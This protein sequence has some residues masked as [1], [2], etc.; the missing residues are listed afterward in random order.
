MSFRLTRASTVSLTVSRGK[1]VV[2]RIKPKLDRGGH[3]FRYRF[4]A[5]GRPGGDY[6]VRVQVVRGSRKIR[7]VLVS[8]RL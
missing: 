7:S 4:S 1:K 3:T 2:T 8:R 6:K 5:K